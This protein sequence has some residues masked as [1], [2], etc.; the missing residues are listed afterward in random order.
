MKY[1]YVF[2]NA[3]L[4][5]KQRVSISEQTHHKL[6]GSLK[7][8]SSSIAEANRVIENLI[9]L[10]D[11][12]FATLNSSESHSLSDAGRAYRTQRGRH[13]PPG[14][15]DWYEFA[16]KSDSLVIESFFDPIYQNLEPFWSLPQK[17]IRNFAKQWPTVLVI[18]DGHP[19]PGASKAGNDDFAL[20]YFVDMLSH[21]P[22]LPDVDLAL[23]G[24]DESFVIVPFAQLEK[25]MEAAEKA[26]LAHNKTPLL[27]IKNSFPSHP[28]ISSVHPDKIPKTKDYVKG[29]DQHWTA[30]SQAC[31]P[32]DVI[33][34]DPGALPSTAFP[35]VHSEK[36][37]MGSPR[38]YVSN[39]T[40]ARSVCA[41]PHLRTLHGIFIDPWEGMAYTKLRPIFSTSN[42]VGI[43]ND[44]VIPMAAQWMDKSIYAGAENKVPWNKKQSETGWWGSAS[45]GNHTAKNWWGFHRHRFVQLLNGTVQSALEADLNRSSRSSVHQ[46]QSDNL[47]NSDW[48]KFNFPYPL[49]SLYPELAGR[50]KLGAWIMKIAHGGFVNMFCSMKEFWWFTMGNGTRTCE[51]TDT[52]YGVIDEINMDHLMQLKYLPDI[53]GHG[54]SGRYLGFIRSLSVPIKSTILTEWHDG[55][56]IPWRHFI[57]MSPEYQEWWGLLQYFLG[58]DDKKMK[59]PRHDEMGEKIGKQGSDWAARAW[60][61]EDLLVY[62][63]RLI[64]EYARICADDRIAMG[65][66]DDLLEKP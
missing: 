3:Y 19:R 16:K 39:W 40:M 52:Y 54:A 48:G 6:P 9:R 5:H 2:V 41:N 25:H 22:N 15:D 31:R 11:E 66:V 4:I 61:K 64:L 37:V 30:I 21:I 34:S 51:H 7:P 1:R 44:I 63:Y 10:A 50:G 45:G 23:N 47:T 18:R 56:I 43:S 28:A 46:L 14:F 42:V 32:Y 33:H 27:K 24:G 62:F 8:I 55:R 17:E 36:Y 53:D 20:G 12:R 65:W 13:P 29:A 60:R 38:G 26:R 49:R 59:V 35:P 58:Y 57:P